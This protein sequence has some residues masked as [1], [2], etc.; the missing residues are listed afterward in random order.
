MALISMCVYSTEEN[1]KDECLDRTLKSLCKT[2]NFQRHRLILSV[3]GHTSKTSEMIMGGNFTLGHVIFNETNLGTAEGINRIWQYRNPGEHV[4]KMDDDV[5]INH[6]GWA[7]IMEDALNRDKS[8]G[9]IG[10]K[11]KDL[12]ESPWHPDPFYKSK[13]QMLPHDPGQ[14]WIVVEE[15]S[16][17][18]GTCVMHSSDLID[19]VGY[20]YQMPGN[21]YGFDDSLMSLRSKLAGFRNCFLPT[22]DIDHI[23]NGGTPFQ[24]WKESNAASRWSEYHKTVAGFKNGTI[25]LYYNPF[26]KSND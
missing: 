16:H 26:K 24:K 4:I 18:M 1:E 10:L 9:Q 25:P 14:R 13:I 3:N 7:D 15:A 12:I 11:R 23:D 17:I 20:L 6:F 21:K 2:V 8:I 19:T 5:V 22:I